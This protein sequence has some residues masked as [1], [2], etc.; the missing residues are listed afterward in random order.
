MKFVSGSALRV[1]L[2]CPS[3]AHDAGEAESSS[4]AVGALVEGRRVPIGDSGRFHGVAVISVDEDVQVFA[5]P[6]I[7]I[8]SS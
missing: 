6:I 7:F 3:C 4:T 5:Y 8:N 2:A 1:R